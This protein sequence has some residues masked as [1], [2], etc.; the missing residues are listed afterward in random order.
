MEERGTPR[1]R[2]GKSIFTAKV[3]A[4]CGIGWSLNFGL[5]NGV[6]I[7][8]AKLS[9]ARAAIA[10][11]FREVRVVRE[12]IPMEQKAISTIAKEAAQRHGV[13]ALLLAAVMTQESGTSLRTDRMRYEPHLQGR[14]KCPAWAN[15]TEC[16]AQATSWGLM[17]VIPGFWGKFCGLQSY[18]DLLDPE[19]NINCGASIMGACLARNTRMSKVE[20]YKLCLGQ[21]N[22]DKTGSY[23]REVLEHLTNLVIEKE[24]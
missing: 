4:M 5:T 20:R 24:L 21:Y 22:G 19:I 6:E 7:A 3:L 13:S 23:A 14:F 18:S 16:K 1:R 10:E 11:R 9:D 15:D 12:Y 17:Q 2:F 8:Q